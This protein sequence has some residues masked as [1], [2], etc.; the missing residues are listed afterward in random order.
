VIRATPGS[1]SSIATSGGAGGF[2]PIGGTSR[3]GAR[4]RLEERAVGSGAAL[5]QDLRMPRPFPSPPRALLALGSALA[6]LAAGTPVARAAK[7]PVS[8]IYD[9]EYGGYV[10]VVRGIERP[11][12]AA[13]SPGGQLPSSPRIAK[14]RARWGL[15]RER[16]AG[17]TGTADPAP[18][19]ADEPSRRWER[20]VGITTQFWVL[21]GDGLPVAGARIYRYTDPSFYAVNDDDT[22]A[23]LFSHYR[24]LPFPYAKESALADV[25]RHDETFQ[26]F[27]FAPVAAAGP[28]IDEGDNPFV[29]DRS[30]PAAPPLEFVGATDAAGS[31]RAVSGIFNLFDPEKFPRAVAPAAIRVGYIVVAD[32]YLPQAVERRH[33]K[34]GVTEGRTLILA[35]APDR[36]VVRAPEY[37]AA[38]AELDQ[39]EWTAADGVPGA[40]ARAADGAVDRALARLA[41]A[42]E[43]VAPESRAEAAAAAEARLVAR[44]YRHAP[45]EARAALAAR[46]AALVPAAP[47]RLYRLA[48]IQAGRVRT[49]SA[50]AA[51]GPAGPPP[52]PDPARDEALATARAALALDAQFLPAYALL[53]ELM[54]LGRAPAAERLRVAQ[55]ALAAQPFDRRARG[56]SAALLLELK[57]DVEAFD[58]LRYTYACTPGLGGDRE[59]AKRLAD[60]YW[61]MG[62]PEKAGA[63]LWML[64]GR[65]PEDPAV[66]V[67]P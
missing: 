16:R 2:D 35:E 48:A 25:L 56:R 27:D 64:T 36:A 47:A 26:D 18:S 66:R 57:K 59:L 60:Y 37:A 32:G 9:G 21:D 14:R 3:P 11:D 17:R 7:E 4:R 53:D 29:R 38:L 63:Y 50:P 49:A 5:R 8:V 42:L 44:R 54:A 15:A 19:G 22:G 46:A 12:L 13:A 1:G 39:V 28:D 58:H 6:V 43:R 65:V 41:P 24:Y 52:A 55:Q 61:R 62:L 33:E 34:G 67:I 51:A 10:P 31:L 20:R 23:R 30:G 40:A 45:G